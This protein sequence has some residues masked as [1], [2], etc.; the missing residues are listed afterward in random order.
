MELIH[1]QAGSI[2]KKIYEKPNNNFVICQ[3]S[4][5]KQ[6]REEKWLFYFK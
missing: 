6:E 3:I 1:N 4:G 2:Y 5:E